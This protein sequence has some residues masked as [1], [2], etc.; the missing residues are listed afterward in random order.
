MIILLVTAIHPQPLKMVHNKMRLKMVTLVNYVLFYFIFSFCY[1]S[2]SFF[3]RYF[4]FFFI[5]AD[6]D[7]GD[8][9]EKIDNGQYYSCVCNNYKF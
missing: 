2:F 4:C 1:I 9:A 6:A 3:L 7:I 8:D 5:L